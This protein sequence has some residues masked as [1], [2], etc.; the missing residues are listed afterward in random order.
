MI[1]KKIIIGMLIG[2]CLLS[3]VVGF[4]L[5]APPQNESSESEDSDDLIDVREDVDNMTNQIKNYTFLRIMENNKYPYNLHLIVETASNGNY[6][7]DSSN[8]QII[9]KTIDEGINVSIV[10]DRGED[11]MSFWYDRIN[12]LIFLTQQ[13][14]TAVR[15]YKL[16][17][18]DDS[19]TL[20]RSDGGISNVTIHDALGFGGTYLDIYSFFGSLDV[21]DIDFAVQILEL[22]ANFETVGVTLFTFNMGVLGVR[23]YDFTQLTRVDS[24]F[25]V[26]WKWSDEDV[27]LWKYDVSAGTFTEMEA[28]GSNTE[29]A[30]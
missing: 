4:M 11:I 8:Q 24:D 25:W 18:S 29:L 6:F 19:F 15:V 1:K 12:E 10:S 27:E 22:N 13:T 20:L 3:V 26:L 21:A 14:A 2:I 28:C 23:T 5:V 16:D 17:L 30:L 7:V 9:L